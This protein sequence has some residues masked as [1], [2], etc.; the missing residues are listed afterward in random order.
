M[1]RTSE[2]HPLRIDVVDAG[3]GRGQIGI[4]FAP[5]KNDRSAFGGPWVRDL[6]QDLQAVE[7]WK[8]KAVVTLIEA[9][10]MLRLGIPNLGAEI[11]GRGMV[12]LHLP[13]RDV[14]TPSAEF[15]A[16]WPAHSEKLRGL[17]DAG[18][19]VLVHCKGGLG[20]AGTISA[21]LLVESGVDPKE[22]ITRVR[23][24]RP[25]AIETRE[26]EVWVKTGPRNRS[27]ES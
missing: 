8:A 22:A 3:A 7:K 27:K 10:E 17:L 11:Q 16:E 18:Q 13:I 4:T 1:T 9:H 26:Q 25:G 5:G 24:A 2:T 19:N 20:R 15:E 14:S 6:A 12:W 21:R 23:A